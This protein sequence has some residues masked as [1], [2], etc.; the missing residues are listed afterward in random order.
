MALSDYH[1]KYTK[2]PPERTDSRLRAKQHELIQVLS[3]LNKDFSQ[4]PVKIAV[5]GCADKREV[6]GHIMVFEEALQKTV[7]ITT[8]DITT[9]HLVGEKNVVQ[10]DCTE[11]IPDAPYD[12][13]YA[14]ILLKF[15]PPEEQWKVLLNSYN[16]LKPGGIS[17]HFMNTD[18]KTEP[19]RMLEEGYWQIPLDDFEKRLDEIHVKHERIPVKTGETLLKDE[20]C[21]VMLR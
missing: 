2:E 5:L 11:P 9:E 4:E 1:L 14:H 21:F 19:T 20:M 16:A 10:H 13:T 12:I 15:M 3:S 8:F 17:F 6:I 7:D 18:G